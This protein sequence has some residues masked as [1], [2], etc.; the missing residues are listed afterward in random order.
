MKLRLLLSLALALVAGLIIWRV[1]HKAPLV[2]PPQAVPPPSS[3]VP[4]TATTTPAAE[5]PVPATTAMAV[6]L[7]TTSPLTSTAPSVTATAAPPAIS[8]GAKEASSPA[9]STEAALESLRIA[10]RSYGSRFGG[11]P[12]GNNAEITRALTGDNSKHVRFLDEA[13]Y[14][15]KGEL[16]DGWSTPYFFHQL[17]GRET[18]IR[19]AG[20]DRRMWTADDIVIR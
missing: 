11:N 18:E 5:P 12:V 2:A 4:V 16:I 17:S 3:A 1:G 10:V 13:H 9:L 20:P 19:S 6:S 7:T 8:A 14:N 15:D